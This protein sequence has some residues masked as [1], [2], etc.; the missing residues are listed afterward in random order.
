MKLFSWGK[1]GG[2]ESKVWG[3]WLIEIKRL[4]SIV[5]LKFEDGSRDAYHDHAFNAVSFLLSGRLIEDLGNS[6][7]VYHPSLLPIWTPRNRMHMVISIGRSWAISF[8]GPWNSQWHEYIPA[9]DENLTLTH[10]RK[11]V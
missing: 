8:R 1:D 7:V 5:I 3:L 9:T 6:A 2:P 10:G 11:V 4:F